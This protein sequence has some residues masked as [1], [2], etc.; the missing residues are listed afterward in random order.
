MT[1][2]LRQYGIACNTLW[3]RTGIA[4]AAIKNILAGDEG[5]RAS[6]KEE[7]MADAAYVVLTS[8]S[9]ETTGNFFMVCKNIDFHLY[10]RMMRYWQVLEMLICQSIELILNLEK[11][12]YFQISSVE[13][14]LLNFYH[15]V[16]K[17]T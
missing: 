6:R 9:T 3:P 15:F 4:T 14:C 16:L 17:N 11:L 5:V 8:K 12:I 1:E 7:I 2:E 10:I 13:L